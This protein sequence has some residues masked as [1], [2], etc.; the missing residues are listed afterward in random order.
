MK[1]LSFLSF[2]GLIFMATACKYEKPQLTNSIKTKIAFG[3]CGREW[4]DQPIF[5][6]VVNH[7][8][9]MFIFLGDN[10]YG[11][12]KS[13]DTL[14]AKYQRLA[15]KS[16]FQNLKQN[17]P[18][19]ATWDDHDYGWNDIGR[20]YEYKKESKEIFLEFFNE[21]AKSERRKHE[22]IYHSLMY[23]YG[24]KKLQVILLDNRTFRDNVK[25]YTD[26]FDDDGRYFYDLEYAPYEHS[27]STFLGEI[28]WEWLEKELN[29]QADI[30]L[31]CS[32]SQF[33][34][35]YNGYESWANFPHEQQRMVDLISKTRANGVV[36]LTGDVHYSEISKLETKGYPIHDFTSSGLSSTWKFATPN[37]NRIEGPIMDNHF[38]MLTI[39][40]ALESPEIKM[41]T[42]DIQDNQRIEYTISLDEIS[43]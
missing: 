41:E 34:I 30:R 37:K 36:F 15:D 32:G 5:N 25:P 27:D 9:D 3:S 20:H 12:T 16:S 29:K 23:E 1:Y 17:V 33:S 6:N 22:G 14:K 8:P 19:L 13:M 10:I 7:E 31:I 39:D 35:E 40:W 18:I 24:D 28:Q 4:Q 2:V 42:W 43:F 11:D 21:P 26:E 38:G